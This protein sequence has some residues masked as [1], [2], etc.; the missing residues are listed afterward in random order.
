MSPLETNTWLV[1]TFLSRSVEMSIHLKRHPRT[2]AQIG[3]R[4]IWDAEVVRA[5]LTSPTILYTS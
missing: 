2:V 5:G 1:K 4:S 3:E